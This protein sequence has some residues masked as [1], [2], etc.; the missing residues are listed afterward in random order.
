MTKRPIKRILF[1]NY[2]LFGKGKIMKKLISILL[3][4]VTLLSALAVMPSAGAETSS[5]EKTTYIP[6]DLAYSNKFGTVYVDGKDLVAESAKGKKVTLAKRTSKSSSFT[7]Y[8]RGKKVIYHDSYSQELYSVG[9]DGKNKKKLGTKIDELLGGYGD[10]VIVYINEGGI[11]KINPKGK[12]TK[13]FETEDDAYKFKFFGGKIYIGCLFSADIMYDLKTKKTSTVTMYDYIIGQNHMYY[14]NRKNFLVQ[15]DK[16]GVKKAVGSNVECI[17]AV[18]NGATVVYSKS[19]VIGDKEY[20]T[21]YRKTKGLKTVELCNEKDIIKKSKSILSNSKKYNVRNI[22]DYFIRDVVIAR[23]NA[24]FNVYFSSV[25]CDDCGDI[26]L[27]VNLNTG[28]IGDAVKVYDGNTDG[29]VF[30]MRYENG[31]IYYEVA[32]LAPNNSG[33]I[34][35]CFYRR[36]KAS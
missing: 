3:T 9:I 27:P 33:L 19:L 34:W 8:M 11:Y 20:E 26:I 28:K 31:Y 17:Y 12:K 5:S 22:G 24:Y 15:V 6:K 30:D 1:S 2:F 36:I 14:M 29:E 7:F 16:Y 35:D 4:V 18:N 10:D 25:H 32:K 13:I 21:F 23:N